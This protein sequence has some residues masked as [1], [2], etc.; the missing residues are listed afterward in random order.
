LPRDDLAL[1]VI[2]GVP[3]VKA[4]WREIIVRNFV[5]LVTFGSGRGG[6]AP[7]GEGA[8]EA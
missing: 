3:F 5:H 4:L 1:W 6:D 7:L 8:F 2:G